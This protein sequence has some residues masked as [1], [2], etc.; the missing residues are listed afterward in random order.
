M[1]VRRFTKEELA[2]CN[3]QGNAPA[4]IACNGKVYDLSRSFLWRNGLHQ[5]IHIAGNDLTADLA[6]APHGT[7]LL[8]RFPVVGMLVED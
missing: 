7:D 4:F 6:Q 1:K 3:G 5:V 8:E 2:E